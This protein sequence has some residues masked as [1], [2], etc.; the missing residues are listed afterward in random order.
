MAVVV[1]KTFSAGEVLTAADLNNSFTRIIDNQGS[2]G[3]PATGSKDM[4]GYEFILDAD[5]DT[6]ITADTDDQI[7]FRL[8]GT[9]YFRMAAGRMSMLSAHLAAAEGAAAASATTTDIWTADGNCRH[10][11]GTT[12]ITSFGTAP[13]AG[14]M[15]WVIFDGALTL[16][17][18]ANLSLPGSANITT[19]ADD[20]ALVYADTTTQFDVLYF[21]KN[22]QAIVESGAISIVGLTEETAVATGDSV[23]IYDLSATANRKM[24][25]ANLLLGTAL[26]VG[27]QV[28]GCWGAESIKPST[29]N[30]SA[31]LVWDE[32]T[33][34]D[35][36]TPYLAYNAASIEYAQFKF[37]APQGLDESSNFTAMIVWT[38]ESGAASHDCVWQIEMQAQG[39]GDTIDSAW[40]TAVTVTDTGTS[41]TRRI[42]AEFAAITP[43][44]T[45]AAG[46]EIIVRVSRKATDVADT[47]DVD[48]KLIE[49]VLFATYAASVEP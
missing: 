21:K 48:A 6:S 35:V 13:Q 15:M 12:T 36:M 8:S 39:D 20:F 49:V 16:T 40:G 17:H 22:G 28:I 34:N 4:D 11:T 37:R 18:G 19:A 29:T 44:G 3:W 43:G 45:W 33:T 41:G 46:D 23:P 27:K 14:A 42:T 7:D 31:V 9:D 47:L 24:T 32:S 2:L 5:A 30:G 1:Y 25:V 10:I 26:K 38:E